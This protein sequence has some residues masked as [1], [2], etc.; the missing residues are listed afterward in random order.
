MLQKEKLLMF[1]N[2]EKKV[3]SPLDKKDS[4]P[5]FKSLL[6]KSQLLKRK[7]M[8]DIMSLLILRQT[9][10]LRNPGKKENK[11]E[12]STETTEPKEEKEENHVKIVEIVRRDLAET[13]NKES[14]EEDKEDVEET[15]DSDI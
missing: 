3:L 6:P 1:G 8:P 12:L 2:P 9:I 15:P 4:L 7:N 11:R 13:E 14:K 5:S 10:L